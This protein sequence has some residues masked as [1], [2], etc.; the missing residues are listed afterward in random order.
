VGRVGEGGTREKEDNEINKEGK[1]QWRNGKEKGAIKQSWLDISL[2][3]WL[4]PWW[5]RK[6][7]SWNVEKRQFL[8]VTSAKMQ[9]QHETLIQVAFKQKPN[10][11]LK[12][13]I[14]DIN[15]IW[16]LQNETFITP[17]VIMLLY[18]VPRKE[19]VALWS[20]RGD[21][22]PYQWSPVSQNNAICYPSTRQFLM[23]IEMHLLHS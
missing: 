4:Q 21:S 5:Y 2:H 18:L 19:T 1:T 8:W 14:R 23:H 16:L 6:Y 7:C 3:F 12:L 13:H 10:N 15:S 11:E 9:L 22:D 20:W 17:C